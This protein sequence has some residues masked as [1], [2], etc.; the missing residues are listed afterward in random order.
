[1][2]FT[3]QAKAQILTEY[4]RTRSMTA[5]QL[6][7]RHVLYILSPNHP[8]IYERDRLLQSIGSL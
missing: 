3:T 4:Y 5:A 7:I 1:M 8:A 6:W 2:N